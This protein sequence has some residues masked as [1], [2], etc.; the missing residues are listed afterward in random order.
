MT[1]EPA[2]IRKHSVTIAGHQ[3]SVTLENA[4][5]EAFSAIAEAQGLSIN[6]LVAEIDDNRSGNLSS[7]IRL[8]VF[9]NSRKT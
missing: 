5:W 1:E 7:A 3:T 6:D 2:T 8:Y 4:F 9:E